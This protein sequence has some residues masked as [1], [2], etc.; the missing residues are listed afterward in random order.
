MQAMGATFQLTNYRFIQ[1]Q[2]GGARGETPSAESQKS[3]MT[4]E[5]NRVLGI[6]GGDSPARGV[7]TASCSL[8]KSKQATGTFSPP[9]PR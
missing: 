6:L 4:S 1:P 8:T 5:K 2:Q 3:A 9:P 7:L